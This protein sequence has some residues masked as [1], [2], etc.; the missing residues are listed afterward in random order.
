MIPPAGIT[1]HSFYE[2]RRRTFHAV[3]SMAWNEPCASV[4]AP[5]SAKVRAR[6]VRLPVIGTN[7]RRCPWGIAYHLYHS[8]AVRTFHAVQSM[9]WRASRAS[10]KAP[11]FSPLA[12]DCRTRL[13]RVIPPAG[14]TLHSYYEQ[15][16]RTFPFPAAGAS[17]PPYGEGILM[18]CRV[19]P[20]LFGR[21]GAQSS[22]SAKV[23]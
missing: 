18:R 14:I 19:T 5:L 22:A 9:A 10:D 8:V 15:R 21:S 13:S 6:F 23:T 11:L 20:A 12:R 2:Q 1:L 4:T 7:D 16:R 17:P 3:R